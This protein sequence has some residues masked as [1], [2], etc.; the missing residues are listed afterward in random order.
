MIAP[1]SIV[2]CVKAQKMIK[3]GCTTW[4]AVISVEEIKEKDASKVPIVKQYLNIFPEDLSGLPLDK[5]INF[6][7]NLVLRIEPISITPYCMVLV[8]LKELKEQL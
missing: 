2:S 3:K 4:I 6:I 7:I 5:E 1:L 8:E